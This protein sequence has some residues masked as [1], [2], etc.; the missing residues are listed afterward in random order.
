MKSLLIILAIT[1][2]CSLPSVASGMFKRTHAD[3]VTWQDVNCTKNSGDL[4]SLPMEK[5][6]RSAQ[7]ESTDA[8]P[9]AKVKDSTRAE[10]QLGVLDLHVLN[11]RRWGKP[12][13]VTRNREARAWHEYW[14][15]ETGPNAGMQLHFVNGRLAGVESTDQ[16]ASELSASKTEVLAER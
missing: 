14:A 13:R 10:F 6:M 16:P 9:R 15:Y 5:P 1:L 4:Q 8:V 7:G 3:T 11:N 12:Q 2:L